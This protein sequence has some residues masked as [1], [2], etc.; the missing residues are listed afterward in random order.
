MMGLVPLQGEKEIPELSL[1]TILEYS[2]KEAICKTE[3]GLSPGVKFASTLMI[4]DFPASRTVRNK[5]PRFKPPN[6][7][8]F[9]IAA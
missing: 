3:R 5:C 8:Y 2:K 4:S 7:W 6:L 1:S 9:V